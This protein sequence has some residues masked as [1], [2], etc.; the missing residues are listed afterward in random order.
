MIKVSDGININPEDLINSNMNQPI[1]DTLEKCWIK[2]TATTKEQKEKQLHDIFHSYLQQLNI[3]LKENRGAEVSD[4]ILEKT[5]ILF[6]TTGVSEW[7][8]GD[9]LKVTNLHRLSLFLYAHA[10]YRLNLLHLN[11]FG[12]HPR[13]VCLRAFENA[14]KLLEVYGEI[15]SSVY[16]QENLIFII[17]K[18]LFD[19]YCLVRQ[20]TPNKETLD[21]ITEDLNVLIDI[22]K[23]EMSKIILI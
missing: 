22:Y 23:E 6:E 4:I 10:R 16:I 2:S 21:K 20:H 7:P 8:S 18:D 5:H 17:F 14:L 19:F 12:K 9:S 1:M 13:E 3:N 15:S 11:R